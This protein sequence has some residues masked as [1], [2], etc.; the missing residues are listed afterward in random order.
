V[1]IRKTFPQVSGL[2]VITECN[3]ADQVPQQNGYNALAAKKAG[4][5]AALSMMFHD[6]HTRDVL[7]EHNIQPISFE[8]LPYAATLTFVDALQEDR[9]NIKSWQFPRACVF[10]NLHINMNPTTVHAIVDL[11]QI[12]IKYWPS[13]ILEFESCLSWVNGASTTKFSI[14]YRTPQNLHLVAPVAHLPARI[15]GKTARRPR[16]KFLR[17]TRRR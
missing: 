17:K 10:N 14:D 5:I 1:I 15:H 4:V 3:G 11:H 12:P 7:D 9:R 6:P 2:R 8:L 16:R 13:K